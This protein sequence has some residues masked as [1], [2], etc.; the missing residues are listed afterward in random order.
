[1]FPQVSAIE[2]HAVRFASRRDD[3]VYRCADI[4]GIHEQCGL[5]RENIQKAPERFR[6]ILVRHHPGMRLRAISVQIELL[7]RQDV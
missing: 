4:I 1:M 2:P 6:F 5:L 7:A 3:F